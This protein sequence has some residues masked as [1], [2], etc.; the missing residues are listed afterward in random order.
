MTAAAV[1]AQRVAEF[2]DEAETQAQEQ[3]AATVKEIFDRLDDNGSGSL[4]RSEVRSLLQQLNKGADPTEEELT[5][6][7]KMAGEGAVPPPGG[8]ADTRSLEIG[9]DNLMA[10][11]TCWKVYQSSFAGEK[12][13]GV[14]LFKKFDPESTGYLEKDQLEA[15]L[16]DLSGGQEVTEDDLDFVLD[17]ADVNRDGRISKMELNQ[18]IAAWYQRQNLLASEAAP[19]KTRRSSVCVVL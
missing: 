13:I 5:F 1:I 18:A 16:S 17:Q 6:V 12:S 10:A 4:D 7:M 9:K 15:M 11:V 2:R 19:P 8:R 14:I 3:R